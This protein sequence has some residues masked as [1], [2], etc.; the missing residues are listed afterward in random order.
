ML[1]Y[2]RHSLDEGYVQMDIALDPDGEAPTP[3][4]QEMRL[5]SLVLNATHATMYL[6]VGAV[7]PGGS[8]QRMD[9]RVSSGGA[10]SPSPC[11]AGEACGGMRPD[12]LLAGRAWAG[13][14]WHQADQRPPCTGHSHRL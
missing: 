7:L 10:L 11:C 13:G 5:V 2:G 6:Q 3:G 14:E 9:S 8:S 4:K 12:V 1:E